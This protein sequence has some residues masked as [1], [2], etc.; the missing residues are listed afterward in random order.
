MLCKLLA[1]L[2]VPVGVLLWSEEP[3]CK[4]KKWQAGEELKNRKEAIVVQ[5]EDNLAV[6]R[7]GKRWSQNQTHWQSW[8]DLRR[9]EG[10]RK[11]VPRFV[12]GTD[13][14]MVTLEWDWTLWEGNRECI[15]NT[16]V[17]SAYHLERTHLVLEFRGL[18]RDKEVVK[19]LEW[20]LTSWTMRK[21]Q[22]GRLALFVHTH[23]ENA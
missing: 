23:K 10:D 6:I 16:D 1:S 7:K 4:S 5:R 8:W 18:G 22:H 13:G 17:Q 2:N 14:W 9:R 11:V 12:T 20:S 15:L 3:C 19:V 21:R